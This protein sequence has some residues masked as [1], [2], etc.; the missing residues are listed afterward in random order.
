MVRVRTVVSVRI[1]QVRLGECS[2][3]GIGLVLGPQQ[4]QGQGEDQG[5]GEELS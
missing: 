2:V 4:C 5:Q 1:G 3:L